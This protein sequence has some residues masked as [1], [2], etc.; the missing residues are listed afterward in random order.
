MYLQ[1]KADDYLDTWKADPHHTPLIIKGPVK[2]GKRK[3]S[4]ILLPATIVRW[5][6]STSSKNRNIEQSRRTGMER[7]PS[8]AIFPSSIQLR[9]L[10][11]AKHSSSS[12]KS[13]LT[14]TLLLEQD[15]FIRTREWLVPVEVKSKKGTAKSMRTLISSDSYP[16]I[17]FGVKLSAGNIGSSEHVF[18]APYFATFLLRRL[19][20][21]FDEGHAPLLDNPSR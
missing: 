14:P 8:S 13:K 2:S 11:Q 12:T 20:R 9:N 6:E 19:L 18:T 15:F 10:F 4:I 3:L 5:W 21:A 16:E 1:R 17:Q 7:T